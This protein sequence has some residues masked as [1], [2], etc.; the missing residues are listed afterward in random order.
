MVEPVRVDLYGTEE[1]LLRE[2]AKHSI[3]LDLDGYPR[4]E[5]NLPLNL[6][7]YDHQGQRFLFGID[8]GPPEQLE[9]YEHNGT[10][11]Q[12]SKKE[13]E[14]GSLEKIKGLLRRGG[15]KSENYLAKDAAT[16]VEEVENGALLF[17]VRGKSV[18][19]GT[20]TIG[21]PVRTEV[22]NK[23]ECLQRL[24]Y[25]ENLA[26]NDQILDNDLLKSNKSRYMGCSHYAETSVHTSPFKSWREMSGTDLELAAHIDVGLDHP[27]AI[28]Y[29]GERYSQEPVFGY[30]INN[31]EGRVEPSE[32]SKEEETIARE[33][34]D[35]V[36]RVENYLED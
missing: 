11:F 16:A 33:L 1:G 12:V 20:R 19:D 7:D 10:P 27:V 29:L 3:N 4:A 22:M 36:K 32:Y 6:E 26:E 31:N 23:D 18:E 24:S 30:R 28:G 17:E 21:E 15:A 14:K 34:N 2:A 9:T 5:V 13:R 25:V 8:G 35:V